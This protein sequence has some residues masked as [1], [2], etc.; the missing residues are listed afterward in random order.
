MPTYE[1][2]CK[3]CGHTFE[4]FQKITANPLRSCPKCK[5]RK[6][7]RLI[8]AGAG[9][10][11]K[12]SGFYQTDYRSE[13]YRKQMKEERSAQESKQPK[14]ESTPSATASKGEKAP[15]AKKE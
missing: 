3:G 10:I 11:F 7:K 5:R 9:F 2:E 14:K 4:V 15:P 6:I 1:Y 8:G 13:N 12:G